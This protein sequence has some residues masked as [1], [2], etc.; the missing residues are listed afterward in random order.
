[1]GCVDHVQILC[2]CNQLQWGGGQVL[3]ASGGL[4]MIPQFCLSFR[5]LSYRKAK[6]SYQWKSE[7]LVFLT[8]KLFYDVKLGT[9]SKILIAYHIARN[10][11]SFSGNKYSLFQR[12]ILQL[13]MWVLIRQGDTKNNGFGSFGGKNSEKYPELPG[14]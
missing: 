8:V 2:Q 5:S 3:G 6:E 12:A 14:R 7:I 1:M 4:Y 13:K 11:K 9:G 10:G